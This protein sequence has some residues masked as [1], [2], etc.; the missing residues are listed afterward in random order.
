MIKLAALTDS[1]ERTRLAC[2]RWR[3]RQRELFLSGFNEALRFRRGRRNE[4][5][6]RVR[7]SE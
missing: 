3:P 6:S 7:S 1:G 2:W 5:A 4:H